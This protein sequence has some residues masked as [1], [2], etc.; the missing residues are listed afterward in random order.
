MH[1]LFISDVVTEGGAAKALTE[2]CEEFVKSGRCECTV[3]TSQ[4]SAFNDNLE[5]LGARTVVTKHGSF[6]VP[7]PNAKWKAPAKYLFEFARYIRGLF[8][9]AAIAA[10]TVDFSTV[11]VIHSNVPRNDLGIFLSRRYRIPHVVHLRECSFAHFNCWS[12]RSDPV[13]YLTRGA[14]MFVA[15]SESTARYWIGLGIPNDKVRTVHDGVR[16][17]EDMG[18]GIPFFKDNKSTK[19]LFLGGYVP[20]KGVWDAVNAFRLLVDRH[21][22]TVTMDIYGG[23]SKEVRKK[24]SRF[25]AENGLEN[26]LS[27]HGVVD[28][29][30]TLI[31]RFDIGMACSSNEGFGRTV[32]EYSVC[33]VVPV[34]SDSGAFPELV[35]NGINGLVYAKAQ[36]GFGL[37]EQLS[38][39]LDDPAL[40][41]KL[42]RS[43]RENGGR[44]SS[45]ESANAVQGVYDDLLRCQG[46][47]AR[48]HGA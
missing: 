24:I 25:V 46:T 27:L 47:P 3:L 39:L 20:A 40:R 12:F 44:F 41:T 23:G 38:K 10:E 34:V 43:A 26:A 7:R 2:L 42:S 4:R 1:I 15:I 37:A 6:L 5:S 35:E 21:G 18:K 11:D 22:E 19:L 16:I 9:S 30:W 33:G 13:G 31:P 32:I 8:V 17:P 14:D 28:D 45:E 36:S 29:V 48:N